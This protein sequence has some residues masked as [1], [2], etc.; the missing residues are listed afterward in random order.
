MNLQVYLHPDAYC[1]K[2][3]VDAHFAVSFRE[4]KRYIIKAVYD[5][6]TPEDIFDALTFDGGVKNNFVDYIKDDRNHGRLMAY[7]IAS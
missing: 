1:G 4:I 3:C 2:S 5:F 6:L 7:E